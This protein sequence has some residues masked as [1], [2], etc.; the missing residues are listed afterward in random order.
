MYNQYPVLEES[1]IMETPG[2]YLVHDRGNHWQK[3]EGNYAK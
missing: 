2:Q 3:M 1:S